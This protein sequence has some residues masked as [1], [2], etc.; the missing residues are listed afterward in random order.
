MLDLFDWFWASVRVGKPRGRSVLAWGTFLE[1][2]E[3][4]KEKS[5]THFGKIYIIHHYRGNMDLAV[6]IPVKSSI[7]S[8]GQT[9]NTSAGSVTSK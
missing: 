1:R 9:L 2:Q 7:D 6:K 3:Q 4:Y 8:C 5:K